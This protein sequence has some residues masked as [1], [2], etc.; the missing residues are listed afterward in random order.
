MRS[1]LHSKEVCANQEE[2][3]SEHDAK[4]LGAIDIYFKRMIAAWNLGNLKEVR[5]FYEL[6]IR[7]KKE[8]S[9]TFVERQEQQRMAV[10][11]CIATQ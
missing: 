2:D 5:K 4:Q 7:H 6:W 10:A 9:H 1:V 3:L 11:K 8:L